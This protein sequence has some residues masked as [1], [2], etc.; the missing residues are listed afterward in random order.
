MKL[1][2]GRK[3]FNA[4]SQTVIDYLKNLSTIVLE[5]EPRYVKLLKVDTDVLK[6]EVSSVTKNYYSVRKSFLYKLLKWFNI[7]YHNISH[8]HID[9]IIAICNDNLRAI[10]N[11]YYH[12][13]VKIKIEDEEAV[14]IVSSNF[15]TI[16]DLEVVNLCAKYHIDTIS[17]DDFNMRIYTTINENSEP[18]VGDR[19]GYGFNIV[20]SE[21]GFSPLKAENFILR[22][23]CTN[24]A[25][26]KIVNDNH[27]FSHYKMD[28]D[29]AKKRI[30]DTLDNSQPIG[31]IFDGKIK[32]ALSTK[33]AL[34]FPNIKY[35]VSGIIGSSKGFKFFNDF[36]E[37][38]SNKYE[39]FNYITDNAKK[40][41]LLE[42]YQLEQ[43]AGNLM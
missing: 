10:E 35:Q 13:F 42:R 15:T 12:S 19:F 18:I 32:K 36:R 11:N 39:L 29:Y 31:S 20:N 30:I 43:L 3:F 6:L 33:A 27:V 22:Y 5:V 2:D 25:T 41:N 40:F 23:W 17:R 37:K 24:G 26:S 1:V 14:S 16:T 8:Y 4:D 28:K 9:T 34:F 7:S 21:T 38:H